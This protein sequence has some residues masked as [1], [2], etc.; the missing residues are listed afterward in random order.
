MSALKALF[1][2]GSTIKDDNGKKDEGLRIYTYNAAELKLHR[3]LTYIER[4]L[5]EASVHYLKLEGYASIIV[6][7]HLPLL[8]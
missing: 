1:R 7:P 8:H 2:R 3:P 6:K 4:E 5:S